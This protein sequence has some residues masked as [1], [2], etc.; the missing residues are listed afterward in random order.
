MNALIHP[1]S[2]S[3]HTR[4]SIYVYFPLAS[5]ACHV[6]DSQAKCRATYQAKCELGREWSRQSSRCVAIPNTY[7]VRTK[8]LFFLRSS[9]SLAAEKKCHCKMKAEN[10]N[11]KIR[12]WAGFLPF[13]DN[14]FW[15]TFA[16]RNTLKPAHTEQWGHQHVYHRF[17]ESTYPHCMVVRINYV[18]GRLHVY[19]S[20]YDSPYDSMNNLPKSQIGIQFFIRH[21]IQ[22]SVYTFQQKSIKI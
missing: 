19:E 15:E 10:L 21:P 12:K 4:Q 16:T 17:C 9:K 7:R 18:R 20:V 8:S 6:P 1:I 11:I 5:C 13:F 22:W 14:K 2:F 3:Y